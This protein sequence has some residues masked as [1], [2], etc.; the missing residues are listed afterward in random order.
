MKFGWNIRNS[1]TVITISFWGSKKTPKWPS[2]NFFGIWPTRVKINRTNHNIH[3]VFYGTCKCNGLTDSFK[4]KSSLTP[5]GQHE[6]IVRLKHCL[7]RLHEW[8]CANGLALNSGKSEA[9]WL[10][11]HQRSRTFSPHN[12]VKV[13]NAYIQISDK[14]KT[15]GVSID[16]K[17]T[18]E[19]H[20]SSICKSCYF[21]IRAF[22]HIR[23][24]LTQDMARSVAV[25]LVGSRLDYANSLLYGTSQATLHKL[26]RNQNS[27]AK[28]VWPGQANLSDASRALHWLPVKHRIEFK[29][30][31]VTFK[32]LKFGTPSY[33]LVSRLTPYVPARSL[34]SYGQQ[35][36]V[37][38]HVKTCVGWRVFRDAAPSIWNSLPLHIRQSPSVDIFRRELKTY[39]FSMNT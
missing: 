4:I 16:S 1:L 29:I 37:R 13:A 36:L 5:S 19:H 27:L 15:L 6:S 20:V 22:R 8:F 26:Q 32:L 33:L 35:L 9:I 24:S 34:C 31:T 11:T 2:C 39:L 17:L 10:S 38:L 30:A 12:P 18:F 14:L 28:L 23:P 25:S 21:H 7:L 3:I